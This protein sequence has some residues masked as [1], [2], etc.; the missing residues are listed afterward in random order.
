MLA[1]Y[2]KCRAIVARYPPFKDGSTVKGLSMGHKLNTIAAASG[3]SF[4]AIP[5]K[6]GKVSGAA[7]RSADALNTLSRAALLGVALTG[8]GAMRQR[9]AAVFKAEAVTLDDYINA[10]NED[11]AIDGSR[12]G[13]LRAL[14]AAELGAGHLTPVKGKAGCMELC[15]VAR[16][17]AEKRYMMAETEKQQS[18]ATARLDTIE[19]IRAMVAKHYALSDAARIA[20]ETE[21][22]HN[23][24]LAF[25]P[26]D[27]RVNADAEVTA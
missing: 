2:W 23:A 25:L 16:L 27:D 3:Y 4:S 20:A 24:D 19:T 21:Q 7:I 6:S 9:A 15:T 18:S 1:L 26:G 11:L 12:Y 13:E 22:S 17:S 8:K 10:A 14:I 5:S